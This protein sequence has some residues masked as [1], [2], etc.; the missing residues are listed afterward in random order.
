MAI[1]ASTQKKV[2][3]K[4]GPGGELRLAAPPGRVAR[5]LAEGKTTGV[6]DTR[7][8]QKKKISNKNE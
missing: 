1:T 7:Y 5:S 6:S 8:K 4:R 3:T 2:T